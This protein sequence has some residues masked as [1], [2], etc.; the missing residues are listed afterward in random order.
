MKLCVLSLS[1]AASEEQREFSCQ[2]EQYIDPQTNFVVSQWGLHHLLKAPGPPQ[3][4]S[5]FHYYRVTFTEEK[6]GSF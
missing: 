3:D 2:R 6:G 1:L 5:S 4:F